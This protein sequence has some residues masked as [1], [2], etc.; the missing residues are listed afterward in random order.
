MRHNLNGLKLVHENKYINL[1]DNL[2][3]K[4]IEPNRNYVFFSPSVFL[5]YVPD[6]HLLND[7]KLIKE[8][9]KACILVVGW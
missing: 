7:W 6:P 8:M 2:Q 4:D 1:S 3:R 5:C 9:S